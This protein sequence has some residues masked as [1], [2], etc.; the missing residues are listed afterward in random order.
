MTKD[1][2]L[3]EYQI[4]AART[5]NR[6][7]PPEDILRH[8]VLG[9]TAEAGEVAGLFQKVYQGHALDAEEL[10]KELGD[11]LWMVSEICEASGFTLTEVASGNIEKLKKRYPDGFSAERSVHRDE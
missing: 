6:S 9:L 2:T 4:Y 7:L 3:N 10:K 1:M 8:G 5:I 11:V